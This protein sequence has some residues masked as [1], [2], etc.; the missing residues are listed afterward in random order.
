MVL[1]SVFS[2]R[3]VEI[4]FLFF[5]FL[6]E[7]QQNKTETNP[8]PMFILKLVHFVKMQLQLKAAVKKRRSVKTLETIF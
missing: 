1:T 3:N 8:Y 2:C 4:L 7:L 5:C 6:Q